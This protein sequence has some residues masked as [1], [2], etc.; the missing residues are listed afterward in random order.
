M[1]GS[2]LLETFLCSSKAKINRLIEGTFEEQE[3]LIN[4]R[5]LL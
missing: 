2:D 5:R 3:S 4:T 1:R